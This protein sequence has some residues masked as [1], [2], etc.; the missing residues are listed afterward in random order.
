LLHTPPLE[1]MSEESNPPLPVGGIIAQ[2]H[3][4]N[5]KPWRDHPPE[6]LGE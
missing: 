2:S 4:N 3:N 6:A 1:Y 5:P